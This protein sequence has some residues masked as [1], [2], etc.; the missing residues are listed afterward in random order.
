M[1]IFCKKIK[2]KNMGDHDVYYLLF[3]LALEFKQI[4]VTVSL[5]TSRRLLPTTSYTQSWLAPEN[6]H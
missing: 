3:R 2:K 4:A 1:K 5:K 6:Q